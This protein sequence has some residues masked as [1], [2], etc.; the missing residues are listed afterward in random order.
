MSAGKMVIG[1]KKNGRW[2]KKKI[3]KMG[4]EIFLKKIER[5]PKM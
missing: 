1:P 3:L 5:A 4:T 2:R